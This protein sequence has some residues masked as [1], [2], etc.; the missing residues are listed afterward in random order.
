MIFSH[1]ASAP[2][3]EQLHARLIRLLAAAGRPSEALVAY[4]EIRRRLADELGVGTGLELRRAYQDILA[5]DSATAAWR[6]PAD[7]VPIR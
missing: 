2:F 1:A 7:G 5:A 4:A 3:N 6:A